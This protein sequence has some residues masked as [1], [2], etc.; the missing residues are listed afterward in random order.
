[1]QLYYIRKE[2]LLED[3]TNKQHV[4]S[5]YLITKDFGSM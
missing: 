4:S 1:M 2:I 5:Y 3:Y